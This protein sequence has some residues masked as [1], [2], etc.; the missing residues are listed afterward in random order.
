[1]TYIEILVKVNI[2]CYFKNNWSK[3]KQKLKKKHNEK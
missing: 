1:M 3:T 2:H